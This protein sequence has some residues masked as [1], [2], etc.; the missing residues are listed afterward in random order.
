M[1]FWM[2]SESM[3]DVDSAVAKA[4][5][6]IEAKVNQLIKNVNINESFEKWA[7][8]VIVVNKELEKSFPEVV[9]KVQ[10]GKVF[11]F[12]LQISHDEFLASDQQKQV[13][14]IFD[15]LSRSIDLMTTL[16][17]KSET[18][19]VLRS[20]LIKARQSMAV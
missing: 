8:I 20:V 18:Q 15:C 19:T 12:R 13:E 7:L 5:R 6:L 1:I 3:S 14:M 16:K 17:V 10:K 11:D 4:S 9:R 2:T